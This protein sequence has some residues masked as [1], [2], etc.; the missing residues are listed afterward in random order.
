NFRGRRRPWT[1]CSPPFAGR[2]TASSI[3]AKSR[4]TAPQPGKRG[5][6]PPGRKSRERLAFLVILPFRN[7]GTPTRSGRRRGPQTAPQA[8]GKTSGSAGRIAKDAAATGAADRFREARPRP[9][10][11][12]WLRPGS[13]PAKSEEHTSEL[14]SRENLV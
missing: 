1:G 13:L 9:A 7:S 12:R 5:K 8:A 14:Q 4:R 2:A 3:R 6:R 11:G 10:R